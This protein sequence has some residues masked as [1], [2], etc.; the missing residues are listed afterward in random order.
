MGP[1]AVA[2]L[3]AIVGSKVQALK[4]SIVNAQATAAAV[5]EARRVFRQDARIFVGSQE[6]EP[7]R[8]GI[9]ARIVA[10]LYVDRTVAWYCVF[11]GRDGQKLAIDYPASTKAALFERLVQAL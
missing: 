1:K 11:L 10:N 9:K 2:E 5:R 7:L 6:N 3:E 4:I 8:R